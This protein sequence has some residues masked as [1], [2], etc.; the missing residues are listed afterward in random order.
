MK[1]PIDNV[2]L[3]VFESLRLDGSDKPVAE[4]NDIEDK[5]QTLR[6]PDCKTVAT[7]VK[8]DKTFLNNTIV[9]V[10]DHVSYV[11]LEAGHEYYAQASLYLTDGTSVK[12]NGNDVVS[13]QKFVPQ[14]G[15]GVVDV[16]IKFDSSGLE[17]GDT[18][19]VVENIY[20]ISTDDE[21]AQGI[22]TEDV[23][24]LS[25]DDLNN[26]DQSLSVSN[27]PISGEVTSRETVAGFVIFFATTGAALIAIVIEIRRK[28]LKRNYRR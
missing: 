18:V 26:K 16:T 14:E 12:N 21:K 13:L 4:H 2:E 6:R 15:S 20:D 7:T 1:I 25:H 11:N 28:I 8:G 22:Q 24:V 9:T 19:V 10:V 3:V 27:I 17:S 23:R 5:D